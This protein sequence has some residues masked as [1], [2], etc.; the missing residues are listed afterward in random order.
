MELSDQHHASAA[1]APGQ[2]P[3]THSTG[4]W[5]VRNTGRDL[6]EEW[7]HLLPLLGFE[8]RVVRP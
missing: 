6:C 3:G 5:A 4:G 7:F 1:V 2:N 8:T